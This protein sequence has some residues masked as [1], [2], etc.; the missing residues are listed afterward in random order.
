MPLYGAPRNYTIRFRVE[1]K[2]NIQIPMRKRGNRVPPREISAF[3]GRSHAKNQSYKQWVE[4]LILR[5]LVNLRVIEYVQG[6]HPVENIQRV[7]RAVGIHKVPEEKVLREALAPELKTKLRNL[8][9][10]QVTLSGVLAQN[11]IRLV[12]TLGLSRTEQRI[13]GFLCISNYSPVLCQSVEFIRSAPIQ[14]SI[15]ATLARILK[16]QVRFVEKALS[17][18]GMLSSAGL[19]TLSDDF[20]ESG[21]ERLR[22][23]SGLADR[24]GSPAQNILELLEPWFQ[25][26]P[27]PQLEVKDYPHILENA[28]LVRDYL[29]NVRGARRRGVNILLYGPPGTGKTELVRALAK[30]IGKN[31]YEVSVEDEGQEALNGKGRLMAGRLA[32]RVL[33]GS[34]DAVLLFDEAEDIFPTSPFGPPDSLRAKGHINQMLET[35]P[36]PTFFVSNSLSGLDKAYLRRFDLII[37]V[38]L[39]PPEVRRKMLTRHLKGLPISED[40]QDQMARNQML[41]PAHIERACKVARVLRPRSTEKTE[42]LISRILTN[43]LTAMGYKMETIHREAFA[44]PAF[45]SKYLN[46]DM[47]LNT[48]LDGLSRHG[49]G[50]FLFSG[51]P[52]TGKS[53]CAVYMAERL[54]RPLLKFSGSSLLGKYVGETEKNLAAAFVRAQ[55]DDAVLVFDELD[56]LLFNRG[57]ARVSYEV[58][59]INELLIQMEGFHGVFVAT[60]NRVT[61]L[62]PA[63]LRRFD[64]KV[65]FDYLTSRQAE[66]LLVESI[67]AAADASHVG[68]AQQHRQRLRALSNLTPG[69]Y[70]AVLRKLTISGQRLSCAKVI[71]GL[72]QE[73]RYKQRGQS[74]PIGFTASL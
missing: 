29:K 32:Q 51:P 73:C 8:E 64:L 40:W 11:I 24:L 41:A 38:P 33:A 55:S 23:T 69:D 25:A 57:M 28:L 27:A 45:S 34:R 13:V 14:L 15:A 53:A 10:A 12:E 58:S 49:Q 21:L 1:T 6:L 72:E 43:N 62:D 48:L 26:A 3:L 9:K 70:A 16:L 39:P 60:T 42:Q 67:K 37:E 47:D 66:E 4:L 20:H 50:R 22:L 30:Q 59:Q 63:A 74:R 44:R 5:I 19:I 56:G 46:A 68:L 17:S 61:A 35:S 7:F 52:G 36:I 18:S 2:S 31:L 65:E 71:D 54:G